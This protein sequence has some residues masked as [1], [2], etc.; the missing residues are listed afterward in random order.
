MWPAHESDPLSDKMVKSLQNTLQGILFD[1]IYICCT[2]KLNFDNIGN[3]VCNK[4]TSFTVFQ[5]V[6]R[7]KDD[8]CTLSQNSITKPSLIGQFIRED[9]IKDRFEILTSGRYKNTTIL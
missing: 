6:K 1:K 8:I 5:K 9:K 3:I 4:G 7:C 2:C